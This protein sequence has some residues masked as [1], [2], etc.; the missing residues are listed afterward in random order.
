MASNVPEFFPF[1]FMVLFKIPPALVILQILAI[2]L[3][4]DMV[5]ALALGAEVPE[6]GTMQQPPR[7]KSKPLLDRELL[8]RAYC[9]LGPIEGVLGMAGFFF[10]WFTQG[11]SFSELQAITPSIVTHSADA[12]TMT[13]YYQAMT[14]TLAAI[15]ATQ[16]GNVFACRSERVSIFRLGFFSNRL[17]WLGI[18]A[19]WLLI[20]AIIYLPPLA[21]IFSTTALQPIHWLALLVCPPIVLMADEFR[22]RLTRKRSSLRNTGI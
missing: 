13:V 21:S 10:V 16:V 20:F 11:Y 6:M 1:L 12:R 22:K 7:E 5:L 3:G 17:I 18:A 4:T 14:M 8:M 2:D 15:V 9:F 19:E